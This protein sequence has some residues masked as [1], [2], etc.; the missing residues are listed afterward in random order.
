MR[1]VAG[2]SLTVYPAANILSYFTGEHLV[3][4]NRDKIDHVSL[5][6]D[7]DLQINDSLGN[8]VRKLKKCWF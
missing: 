3:I 1:I 2:T 6:E 8:V 5:C 4:I 7:T